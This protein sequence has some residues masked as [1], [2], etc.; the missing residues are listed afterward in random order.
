MQRLGLASEDAEGN[1]VARPATVAKMEELRKEISG[2]ADRTVSAQLRDET[3]VKKIIDAVTEPVSGDLFRNARALRTQQARKY[4]NRS[5]VANLITNRRGMDDPKVAADQVLRKS[6]LNASPDEV[7]F[8]KRVMLTSGEDGKQAWKDIQ[9]A[10]VNHIKEE[11]TKGAGRDANDQPLVSG[12][13]LNA[14]VKQ[15]D[16]NDRL[17]IV[18]GKE[19]ANRVRDLNDV[20][21]YINTVPP[22]TLINNSGTARALLSAIGE[23]VAL[24]STT[25]VP[26]PV[27]TT[28]K[29]LQGEIKNAKIKAKIK[30]A[31]EE[32]KTETSAPPF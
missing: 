31:L 14:V 24:G 7:T 17:D 9:G 16:R 12:A 3:V 18:L 23:S 20:L 19:R 21:A 10:L 30:K 32:P 29:L 8:L 25:G 2:V 22:G 1:L 28:L 5:I 4:E 15:L 26:L 13:R 11:A 27:L 6:I